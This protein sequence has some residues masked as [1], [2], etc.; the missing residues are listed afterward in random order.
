[1]LARRRVAKTC[2]TD[3]DEEVRMTDVTGATAAGQG[4][5]RAQQA[6]GAAQDKAQ[7]AAG[8]AQDKAQQAA[9][10]AQDKASQVA[11][12]VQGQAQ[13]VAGQAQ[14]L[15]RSQVDQRSTQAGQQVNTTASDIRSV[16]QQ[17]RSQ[18]KDAPAKLAE[19]AAD[20]IQGIGSYLERSDGDRILH[21]VE[22]LARRQPWV[23]MVGGLLAGFAA[24]RF[25]KASSTQRY[26]TRSGPNDQ[27]RYGRTPGSVYGGTSS[28]P[29]SGT[30]GGTG[31]Y[32]SPSALP[33]A[34]GT[35]P[36]GGTTPLSDRP[37]GGGF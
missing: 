35:G 26:E 13:Q 14:G 34:T 1:V 3:E 28:Y 8:A 18:G 20:R 17:L 22:D 11:G 31:T 4:P 19:Q 15:L 6:T 16:A 24:S 5:G 2:D 9:G 36:A 30:S 29:S 32:G 12:Q 21:D 7:Q 25:L 23:V 10:A 27:G 37:A 33:P